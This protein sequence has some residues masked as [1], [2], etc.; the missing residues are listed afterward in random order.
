LVVDD[1]E[2]PRQSL[3]A[4]LSGRYEVVTA[5]DADGALKALTLEPVDLVLLDVILPGRD[6]IAV[7]KDIR[8]R[9]PAMPVI[10]VSAST[11]VKP[12]VEAM[13]MGAQDYVSK[14]FD[15]EEMLHLAQRAIE[16]GVLHRRVEALESDIAREF[17]A[18][19]V[20]GQAPSFMAALSDLRK[21]A[22][23]E[24]TVL[25]Q[26]ESGTGKELAARMLHSLSSRRS[27]PFVPVHCAAI[28]ETLMESE[29]FGYEKGAFTGA[30]RRKPGRFD[31]AGSGTIFFDEVG[32]MTLQTQVKLLRVLQEREFMRVGGTQVIKTNA[33]VVAA[34]CKDLR[35]E[36]AAGRFREDLF[37]RLSV[38]PVRLPPLRERVGDVARLAKYFME[39]SRSGLGATTEGFSPDA[40]E[41]MNSYQWP[42]NV[43]ELRNVVERTMVLHGRE[44]QVLPRHLP[45]ELC[46]SGRTRSS[47][48]SGSLED[49]VSRYE[50][51]IIED[52]LARS[53]GVQTRAAELLGTTRRILGYRIQRLGISSPPEAV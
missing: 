16:G 39:Q 49:M 44:K 37:Y 13:R 21:A 30:E 32:E 51:E 9:Y 19:D 42:G 10:M 52:A 18:G 17:P 22:A 7:L 29:L 33:R 25:V 12:V 11:S 4:I 8:D 34:T 3:K 36:A 45:A 43:R 23:A 1:E 15:V 50:R 35:K 40:V 20:V 14:P 26:G 41:C 47:P 53:G 31:L 27:E 2:G 5:A 24:A 38:V 48:A 6:G 46:K 28:P